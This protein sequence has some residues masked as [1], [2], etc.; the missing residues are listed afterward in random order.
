MK[1]AFLTETSPL[2]ED[3]HHIYSRFR[4]YS[5]F[6]SGLLAQ[7]G[8]TSVSLLALP[9]T[10]KAGAWEAAKARF[11]ANPHTAEETSIFLEHLPTACQANV[12]L[13]LID[14]A[15]HYAYDLVIFGIFN[16]PPRKL[17]RFLA[18]YEHVLTGSQQYLYLDSDQEFSRHAN[19]FV[20]HSVPFL[21]YL[22]T[23]PEEHPLRRKLGAIVVTEPPVVG[24][25]QAL[26]SAFQVP[27]LYCPVIEYPRFKQ[28]VW[29]L[30]TLP[31]KHDVDVI[32]LRYFDRWCAHA[33][34]REDFLSTLR[35]DGTSVAWFEPS[36]PAGGNTR[37]PEFT[38]Y[39]LEARSAHF[40]T[41]TTMSNKIRGALLYIGLS[42]PSGYRFTY[43]IVESTRAGVL[44]LVQDLR[45]ILGE[46]P[47]A[48]QQLYT[49]WVF[50]S[51][52]LHA[53]ATNY[54][55]PDLGKSL[56]ASVRVA[57]PWRA[58]RQEYVAALNEQRGFVHEYFMLDSGHVQGLLARIAAALTTGGA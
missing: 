49:R 37:R 56:R 12:H 36:L 35:D 50:G 16:H 20:T 17:R 11:R 53:L 46:L 9:V 52:R 33:G 30:D 6:L 57:K 2:F 18:Y 7:L 58:D 13:E 42:T 44:C 28:P 41:R 43:K 34:V 1:V 15:Q 55:S 10:T 3:I 26:A 54:V 22:H 40:F 32:F 5:A 39:G 25:F 4:F 31:D 8:A 38:R 48:S 21:R 45:P 47:Q 14:L 51:R 19:L 24:Y 27:V 29:T 23:L